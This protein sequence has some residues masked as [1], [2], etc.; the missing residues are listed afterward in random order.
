MPLVH[1]VIARLKDAG[2]E[3]VPVVVGGIIPAADASELKTA[4]LPRSTR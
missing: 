4:S 1:D 2:L 3:D